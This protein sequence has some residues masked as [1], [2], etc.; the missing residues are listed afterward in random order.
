M[1]VYWR[2]VVF[3][4]AAF[5]AFEWNSFGQTWGYG[6]ELE[7]QHHQTDWTPGAGV[8]VDVAPK[9]RK[10]PEEPFDPGTPLPFESKKI[11][12]QKWFCI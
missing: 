5:L 4:P 9:Q 12:V 10:E 7:F 8:A 1:L 2:V 6:D 3:L 11:T